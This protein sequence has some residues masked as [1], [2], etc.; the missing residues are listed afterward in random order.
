[1]GS[2]AAKS[3][4][5]N[6]A[7]AAGRTL[8]NTLFLR[9]EQCE[10]GQPPAARMQ[11]LPAAP[12]GI[13]EDAEGSTASSRSSSYRDTPATT[14]P[15]RNKHSD[16]A[17]PSTSRSNAYDP[18]GATSQPPAE[19]DIQRSALSSNVTAGDAGIPQLVRYFDHFRQTRPSAS[20]TA[21]WALS[22]CDGRTDRRL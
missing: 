2:Q 6:T 7:A 22:P 21:T 20:G 4:R 10:E 19:E 9:Q 17:V 8:H 3:R 1:M 14:A 11:A 5:A 16:G 12:R 18:E 13:P 15:S